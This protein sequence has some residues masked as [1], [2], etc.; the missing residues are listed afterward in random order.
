MFVV[1]AEDSHL[2]E[3]GKTA[4]SSFSVLKED[5]LE[6]QSSDDLNSGV[7]VRILPVR[8]CPKELLPD[9]LTLFVCLLK[10]GLLDLEI[11]ILSAPTAWAD[12]SNNTGSSMNTKI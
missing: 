11:T 2:S 7:T 5:E 6:A 9:Q 1:T 4:S 3:S 10:V 8:C 12:P